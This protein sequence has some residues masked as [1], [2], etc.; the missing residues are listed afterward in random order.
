VSPLKEGPQ[1]PVVDIPAPITVLARPVI[2][3][4]RVIN[5]LYIY[6]EVIVQKNE[7]STSHQEGMKESRYCVELPLLIDCQKKVPRLM[8]NTPKIHFPY[9]QDLLQVGVGR[10]LPSHLA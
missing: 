3:R 9:G 10:Q 1:R 4:R 7:S 6:K 2:V 8:F 5:I